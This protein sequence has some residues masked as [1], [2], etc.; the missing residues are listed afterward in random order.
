MELQISSGQKDDQIKVIALSE[1][2]LHQWNQL[3]STTNWEKGKIICQWRDTLQAEGFSPH[4]FSDEAW[5]R[6]IG[7]VTPQHA[8]RLRKV[9]IRFGS[10]WQDYPGLYWS[11]FYAA[12][13]WEDSEL[14]LEGAIQ[15]RWSITQM[16]SARSK[17]QEEVKHTTAQVDDIRL[18]DIQED[19]VLGIDASSRVAS[20]RNKNNSTTEMPQ[21]EDS[22][23]FSRSKLNTETASPDPLSEQML[24]E[25]TWPKD[26]QKVFRRLEKILLK[27]KESTWKEVNRESVLMKFDQLKQQI[28]Q[29]R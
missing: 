26:L 14:W 20:S 7:N 1:Q 19:I 12:L 3:V 22:V 5:S 13:D 6:H 21:L 23:A 29:P 18:Q 17:A 10:V 8:G 9:F 24:G 28:Q 11:H 27:H 2:F 4:H 25:S 15:N 16:R